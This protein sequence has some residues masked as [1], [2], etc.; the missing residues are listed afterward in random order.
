MLLCVVERHEAVKVRA[1]AV[2]GVVAISFSAVWVRLAAAPPE[3]A[4]FLRMAYALPLL[5]PLW[6]VV[7]RRDGRTHGERLLAVVAGVVLAVDLSFWHRSIA[8]IGAGLATVLGNTQVVFV[9]AAAWLLHRERPKLL[10]RLLVPGVLGGV[11]LISGLGL[12]DAYGADPVAGAVY[13]LLTG[14]CYATF[15]LLLRAA[16]RSL[17]PA[18]GPLLDA[19]VGAAL[20]ALVIGLADGGLRLDLGW[21][22][23]GWLIALALGSQVLGWLLITGALPRMAALEASV[24]LLLQPLATVLWGALI[25]AE[26]VSAVQWAGVVLV[27]AGVGLLSLWG[28]VDAPDPVRGRSLHDAAV[29]GTLAAECEE[30][31]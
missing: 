18:V 11:V 12:P 27:L 19:T 6:L 26:A 21:P 16:N 15:L 8:H 25:F 24:M 23:H 28:S 5:V 13:G 30:E 22:A 14:I 9:G 1:H 3:T 31:S 10:A 17:A 4:A 29:S 20:G 2:V 7:R